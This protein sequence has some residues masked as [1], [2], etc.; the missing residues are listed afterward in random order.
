MC[1]R[2]RSAS[3]GPQRLTPRVNDKPGEPGGGFTLKI[4]PPRSR[5]SLKM[6][7]VLPLPNHHL[8]P[9]DDRFRLRVAAGIRFVGGGT[10]EAP[11]ATGNFPFPVQRAHGRR[12]PA[13]RTRCLAGFAINPGTVQIWVSISAR[14]CCS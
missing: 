14:S 8:Q 2:E 3:G 6:A 4:V 9:V 11:T 12:D 5:K 1:R 13:I 10:V 7:E